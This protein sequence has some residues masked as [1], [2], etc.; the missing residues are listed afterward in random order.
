[1]T[2]TPFST[3]DS[4]TGATPEGCQSHHQSSQATAYYLPHRWT[5]QHKGEGQADFPGRPHAGD[6]LSV[7]PYP[8]LGLHVRPTDFVI[9][10]KYSL[11]VP[12][13]SEDSSQLATTTVM[14][15][16]T[17]PSLVATK[18]IG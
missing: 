7:L 3:I 4:S 8:I 6:W 18:E 12:M 13:F 15:W 16:V 2:S 14:C 5:R 11:S 17:M 1:M 9:S 10:V